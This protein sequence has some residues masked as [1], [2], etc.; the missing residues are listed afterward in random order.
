MTRTRAASLASLAVFI[1][2]LVLVSSFNLFDTK[3]TPPPHELLATRVE[4]NPAT[5]DVDGRINITLFTTSIR[6]MGCY[7][8]IYRTFLNS[9][10]GEVVYQVVAIG[11][12]VPAT[13]KPVEF[14]YKASLPAAR[15]P[16][17]NYG[18]TAYA[19][20]RC[21]EDRVYVSPSIMSFFRV[22]P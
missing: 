2:G 1:F 7:T 13:G 15:F 14:P 16:P 6:R 20:N 11:G 21:A 22:V 10:T 9:D 19:I 12:S 5:A 4:P 8:Q 17:G 18:Y 3:K